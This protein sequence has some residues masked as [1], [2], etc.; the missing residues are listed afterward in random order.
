MRAGRG[1]AEYR[2]AKASSRRW[3]R[4][5]ISRWAARE[6]ENGEFDEREGIAVREFQQHPSI[7]PAGTVGPGVE[8]AVG[9]YEAQR[10]EMEALDHLRL[11]GVL[12]ASGGQNHDDRIR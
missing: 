8:Q 3:L 9:V 5:T 12:P 2:P 11:D 4:G 6:A 1:S 10:G 7:R